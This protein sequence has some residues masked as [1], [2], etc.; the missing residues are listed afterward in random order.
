MTER[1]RNF[2][3]LHLR[4]EYRKQRREVKFAAVRTADRYLRTAL[5]VKQLCEAEDLRLYPDDIFGFN[6]STSSFPE[7]DEF[8]PTNFTP[9]YPFALKNGLSGMIDE[10]SRLK[11]ENPGKEAF[12]DGAIAGISALCDLARRQEEEAR[13]Q[14]NDCLADGLCAILSRPPESY[15]E[16]LLTQRAVIY[17]LRAGWMDHVTLG[18]FDVY[19]E[20]FY[21]NSLRAGM[22]NE[23]LLELTELYFISLNLDTDLYRGIQQGDNGQSLVLGGRTKEC[24]DVFS[25]LSEVVLTAS[26]EL[27]LIDP[28]INL[29]VDRNTPLQR[30]E[31]GTRLTAKGLGFPQYCNDDVVIDGLLAL[32]YDYEDAVD[33]T[34]AACWEFI[35]PYVSYDVV[36]LRTLN[37]PA[38]VREATVGHLCDCRNFE[39][40]YT[41]ATAVVGEQFLQHVRSGMEL[42]RGDDRPDPVVSV[43][44]RPCRER[45]LD[46]TE[47]G[48]KYN[49][50]GIHGLGIAPAVDALAAIKTRVFEEKSISPE[51]L[52]A[53]LE[54][55]FEGYG[56]LRSLL[57][58]APKMGNNEDVTNEI[59]VRLMKDYARMVNGTPNGKPGGIWRAGTGGSMDYVYMARGVGATADGRRADE[60]YPSSFSPSLGVKANGLLSVV[61]SFTKPDLRKTVNGGPLTVEIHETVFSHPDGLG[62]V[63]LLVQNFIRMGGH[64]LQLNAIARE[65]LLDA[66]AHPE[67]YPDLIV[68]VWGWSGYFNELDL[69]FQNQII[70]RTEY[71]I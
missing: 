9:D 58:T 19:M 50:Y 14:G 12:Y 24:E 13:R 51:E 67:K 4:R 61:S 37:F 33:Y 52:I 65:K 71:G 21:R 17:L 68:R 42:M 38:A 7:T 34:L 44:I 36:N 8:R 32:G 56:A 23:E 16:A 30:F 57:L 25:D 35:V 11:A 60:P 46:R 1:V 39:E 26:E 5:A 20:P 3:A 22:T 48:A 59:A 45:G 18:R 49:H 62:K 41:L 70:S 15:Y 10:L 29:R 27:C 28:K 64:Q 43:F 53:A 54:A 6:H 2:L 55:N 40:F 47:G 66:Q 63:A 31:R 69:C